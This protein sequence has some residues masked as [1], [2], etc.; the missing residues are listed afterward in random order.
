M[1]MIELTSADGHVFDAYESVG[2]GATAA[3]VVVQEIFGVNSHI[4]SVVDEYAAAGFHAV[5]PALFDRVERNVE[6]GYDK[7][8]VETGRKIRQAIEWSDATAD[9]AAT[10]DYLASTG[11]VG[12]VGYCYGG[13]MAWLAAGLHGVRAAVGYYGGQ[14]VRFI[15][16]IPVAPVM[17][18][19][20]GLDASIPAS[21]VA[22][23]RAAY[24]E[25]AIHVYETADHGFNCDQRASYNPDAAEL[26][27][28]RTLEFFA[29]NL[30]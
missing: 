13:S 8:G 19:F 5:A 28:A 10:L 30:A 11:P 16:T 1:G 24:P 18:H 3:I 7:A 17:L 23:I 20:G 27:R 26:A 15:N 12:V 21:D 9:V 4:R 14:I 22:A 2:P 29:T 25:L 6:L